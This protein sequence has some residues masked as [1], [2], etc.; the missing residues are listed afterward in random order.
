VLL[1][2]IVV[3]VLSGSQQWATSNTPDS[4]F[5]G[6]LGVFGSE[7][8]DRAPTAAYYWTRL[9]YIGPMRLLTSFI[10]V[11]AGQWCFRLLLIA[12][13]LSAIFMVLRPKLGE[14]TSIFVACT[15]G[16]NTVLLSF[17]GNT[18]VT[19]TVLAIS[20][21]ALALSYNGT[22]PRTT[23]L[24]LVLNG[25]LSGVLIIWTLMCNPYA[26]V[27]LGCGVACI[28]V[29]RIAINRAKS[30]R[31]LATFALW[32]VPGMISTYFGFILVGKRIFPDLDWFATYRYWNSVLRQADYMIDGFSWRIDNALLVPAS[33][34]L[35]CLI[36]LGIA[37]RVTYRAK[38]PLHRHLHLDDDLS[39]I[40]IAATVS[41]GSL[42]FALLYLWRSPGVTLEWT[43]YQAMLWAPAMV[44]LALL[45][46]VI[47]PDLGATS[48]ICFSLVSLMVVIIAGHWAESL[49]NPFARLLGLLLLSVICLS[50]FYR[51]RIHEYS[52]LKSVMVSLVLLALVPS[53]FQVLQNSRRSPYINDPQQYYSNAF[54]PNTV[55]AQVTASERAEEWLLSRTSSD[56]K[57]MTW[58][59]A[60]WVRGEESLLPMAA[61]QLDGPNRITS[62]R[63]SSTAELER[64][65]TVKPSV[66]A[67]YTKSV[68]I[69]LGFRSGLPAEWHSTDPE[70]REFSWPDPMVPRAF[71]CLTRVHW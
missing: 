28:I 33:I 67:M 51:F 25:F 12:A 41:V 50:L 14:I 16:V 64:A 27:L 1:G 60:D 32:M 38:D 11:D 8:T 10:G 7:V 22:V 68:G 17:A 3:G 21:L 24:T 65:A 70:C 26:A 63:V 36:A 61:Y 58:V 43:Q 40:L 47:L 6:S 19:G 34:A 39:R 69:A 9:G 31:A 52:I 59:D 29:G 66:I 56:D 35:T 55:S 30:F 57:I 15:L 4:E 42:A 71:L 53:V 54:L 2:T 48:R 46:S 5:Y 20:M 44:G 23:Q 37:L 18:Y 45:Y 13:M 49:P 62:G